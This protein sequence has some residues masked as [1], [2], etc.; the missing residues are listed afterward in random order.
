MRF[1]SSFFFALAAAFIFGNAQAAETCN[2]TPYAS[3]P[4]EI[5]GDGRI[6]V[7][8]TIN[9][10]TVKLRL[11]LAEFETL[12][13]PATVRRLGLTELLGGANN[14]TLHLGDGEIVRYLV[15][16]HHVQLGQLARDELTADVIEHM[17][18]GID[19]Q[20]GT[21]WF[22]GYDIEI[23]PAGRRLNL[24][25]QDHCPGKVV[26]W[27]DSFFAVDVHYNPRGGRMRAD[28]TLD[29]KAMVALFDTGTPQTTIAA[30]AA[31]TLFGL[32]A[33]DPGVEP[34]VVSSISGR[35]TPGYQHVFGALQFGPL[36]FANK[37]IAILDIPPAYSAEGGVLLLGMDV[38]GKLR[39][40]IA[41]HEQK[42][43][44]TMADDGHDR[45]QPAPRADK[46]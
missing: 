23:N 19:G 35:T 7:P 28:A 34:Y 8:V 31:Q 29:G 30:S 33:K 36:S 17:A 6:L 18:D 14:Q 16:T 26:Y 39:S 27:A 42:F 32:S 3:I 1:P 2:L 24:F 5:A 25:S 40:F 12:L 4:I 20:I 38:I 11:E 37:K 21:Q 9:G 13:S 41:F 44:F 22:G 15:Q 45:A 10:M 43:Y 46:P